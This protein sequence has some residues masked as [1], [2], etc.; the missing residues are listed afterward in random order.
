MVH[1]EDRAAVEAR[2]TRE[3]LNK[4]PQFEMEHRIVRNADQAVR[5]VRAVGKV[6]FDSLGCPAKLRGTIQDIT[7]VKEAEA[8][9]RE[10]KELLQ[11]FIRHAPVMKSSE[12]TAPTSARSADG[13]I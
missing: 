3:A 7:E 13:W 8:A 2:F 1:P 6:E 4:S 5:W 12:S 9:L 10:S 11:L